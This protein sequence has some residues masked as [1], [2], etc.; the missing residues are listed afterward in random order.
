MMDKQHIGQVEV[1]EFPEINSRQVQ[2]RIDTGARTSA[3]WASKTVETDAGLA[4]VFFD[5]KSQHNS[6]KLIIFKEFSTVNVI[7][8]TGTS[9]ERYKVKLLVI[10]GGRK[11]RAWFTL[12]DRSKQTYP[13]LIG[14]NILRS[15]FVVDVSR[16]VSTLPES[17]TRHK[18]LTGKLKEVQS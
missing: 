6:E 3:I 12:A 13:V 15:K 5:K 17:N 2:A 7:S 4:V 16:K 10:I 9:Q 1:I 11:I 18:K 8:S 14:R